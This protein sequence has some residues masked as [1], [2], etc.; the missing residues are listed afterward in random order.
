MKRY[1][2]F[3]GDHY[4]PSGGMNDFKG[5]FDTV[6]EAVMRIGDNDWWHVYDIQKDQ[7][8]DPDPMSGPDLIEWAKQ[9]DG[10]Q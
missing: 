3:A 7:K 4:Y 1:M 9:L 6:L 8:L 10:E 5:T 2:L